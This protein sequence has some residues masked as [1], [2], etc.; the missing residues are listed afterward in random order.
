MKDFSEVGKMFGDLHQSSFDADPDSLAKLQFLHQLNSCM[1]QWTEMVC[2]R[3][4]LQG[5]IY[6]DTAIEL[7]VNLESSEEEYNI[8]TKVCT[9]VLLG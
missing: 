3:G 6:H 5:S 1:A 8:T 2:L 4:S 7:S 9:K